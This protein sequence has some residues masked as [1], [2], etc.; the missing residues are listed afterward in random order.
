MLALKKALEDKNIKNFRI[1]PQ[2]SE[3]FEYLYEVNTHP[4]ADE[5]YKA[6][7]KK[8]SSISLSTVYNSLMAFKNAGEECGDI[9]DLNYS[10]FEMVQNFAIEHT[11]FQIFSHSVEFQGLCENCQTEQ[12]LKETS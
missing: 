1:T 7:K 5:I 11:G 4:T 9:Q 10:T 12:Q 2:R 8:Y 6:L 3:I